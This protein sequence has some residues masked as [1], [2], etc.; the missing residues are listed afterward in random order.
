[1]SS[2]REWLAW[3]C[4]KDLLGLVLVSE[5]YSRLVWLQDEFVMDVHL[6]F[7]SYCFCDKGICPCIVQQAY[8]CMHLSLHF[9]AY[10]FCDKGI[11]PLTVQQ[12]Y[13]CMHL[14]CTCMRIACA[15]KAPLYCSTG[16]RLYAPSLHFQACCFCDRGTLFF[17]F[18]LDAPLA[19]ERPLHGKPP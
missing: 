1:M 11:C 2:I 8:V 9:Q 14:F 7:H 16:V 15:T 10:C 17:R 19:C 18:S 3:S 13:V 12:A 6:H 5:I 4:Q